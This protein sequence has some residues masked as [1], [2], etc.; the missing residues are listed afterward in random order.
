[1]SSKI[2]IFTAPSITNYKAWQ[3]ICYTWWNFPEQPL[4]PTSGAYS[5]KCPNSLQSHCCFQHEC[6]MWRKPWS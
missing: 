2:V 3:I 1:M 6:V 5:G 4:L